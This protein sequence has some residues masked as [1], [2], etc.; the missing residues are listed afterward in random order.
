MFT[1]REMY[2]SGVVVWPVQAPG[3]ELRTCLFGGRTGF[4]TASV[5]SSSRLGVMAWQGFFLGKARV[6]VFPKEMADGRW[7]GSVG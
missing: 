4:R 2:V 6:R 7:P 5:Q 1:Y 3:V